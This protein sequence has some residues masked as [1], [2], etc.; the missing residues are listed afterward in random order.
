MR[1]CVGANK[2]RICNVKI[3]KQMRSALTIQPNPSTISRCAEAIPYKHIC[4]FVLASLPSGIFQ[5][6]LENDK[7][8]RV[9]WFLSVS[10]SYQ[11]FRFPNTVLATHLSKSGLAYLPR[12][13]ALFTKRHVHKKVLA[14]DVVIN[15]KKCEII[16]SS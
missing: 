12:K 7:E 13:T 9:R 16:L 6:Q 10:K 14:L 8:Y 2:C 5:Q 4:S 3:A 11:V 1:F 15:S